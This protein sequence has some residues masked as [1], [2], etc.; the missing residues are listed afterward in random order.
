M[1]GGSIATNMI[2]NIKPIFLDN[3]QSE[4]KDQKKSWLNTIM[5]PFFGE[6]NKDTNQR[7]GGF[8]DSITSSFFGKKNEKT[9]EREGGFLDGITS[10]FFGKKN[11]KTNEREGGFLDGITSSFFGKKNEKTNE[12]E[13][14]FLDSI[15]SSF[16]GKKNEATNKT[17]GGLVNNIWE[18]TTSSANDKT[19]WGDEY[20]NNSNWSSRKGVGNKLMGGASKA[21]GYLGAGATLLGGGLLTVGSA[22]AGG[23]ATV[24]TAIAGGLAT[25]GTAIAGGVAAGST[26][27]A[28]GVA[29]GS[30]ALAGGIATG[31]T[32]LA[33]GI[34]TAGLG[35]GAGLIGGGALLGKAALHYGSMGASGV[36]G[37]FS[38]DK[39]EGATHA[40]Y[41]DDWDKIDANHLDQMKRNKDHQFSKD[42]LPKGYHADGRENYGETENYQKGGY[43]STGIGGI[44][45]FSNMISKKAGVADETIRNVGISAGSFGAVGALTNA[46]TD[47]SRGFDKG[48]ST[49][50]K[51][52]AGADV[53]LD[54]ADG[55]SSFSSLMTTAEH[56]ANMSGMFSII[57]GSLEIVRG[58]IGVKNAYDRK[59]S[60]NN[61]LIKV[62]TS[63]CTINKLNNVEPNYDEKEI[64]RLVYSDNETDKKS[65]SDILR[66]YQGDK[67]GE[68]H[69]LANI[70]DDVSKIQDRNK[71][72]AFGQ[73][74]KGALAVAGGAVLLALGG[75]VAASPVG[76]VL[77]GAAAVAGIGM[78]IYNQIQKGKSKKEI[79][80]RELNVD[81]IKQ[82]E[83]DEK[84]EST[85]SIWNKF[86]DADKT[87][88]ELEKQGTSP[89]DKELRKHE[90][91]NI[92]H[93][94]S[95][96]INATSHKIVYE[97]YVIGNVEY[98][99]IVEGLGFK[100][101]VNIDKDKIPKPDDPLQY[102]PTP[103]QIATQL[104]N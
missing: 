71:N 13:G 52:K 62:L 44:L 63:M 60:S 40:K 92:D 69:E 104:N 19:K 90:F 80:I 42:A 36:K 94:Y 101:K 26:A 97:A 9:N 37:I 77:L 22:I 81:R 96:Y 11:E 76:W 27:I 89:L 8:L 91:S 12:R 15:T 2:K 58:A 49:S 4:G 21:L 23:L 100:T 48:T 70:S 28:G 47:A 29:A 3:A 86:S 95:N 73:I 83:W 51:I 32:A 30:T 72:T 17:E 34:A 78:L 43:V 66:T 64:K 41:G 79:A 53:T 54:I 99:G 102:Y 25:G 55:V 45:N 88:E 10:S 35:V 61:V 7:E 74:A 85:N 65:I 67:A 24:G 93:F 5:N 84:H 57:T 33:G 14:G 18:G 20:L 50:T 31:G 39:Y 6:K 16:F 75:A 68:Y 59:E 82:N 1:T 38:P 56:A 98:D 87:R 103:K 46:V